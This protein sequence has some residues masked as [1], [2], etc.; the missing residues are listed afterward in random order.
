MIDC[1]Q[2]WATVYSIILSTVRRRRI[3]SKLSVCATIMSPILILSCHTLTL[4]HLS[5]NIQIPQTSQTY[6][7]VVNYQECRNF[8]QALQI[9]IVFYS[10]AICFSFADF[11][12]YHGSIWYTQ[13]E[14]WADLYAN[15]YTICGKYFHLV[16]HQLLTCWRRWKDSVLFLF[17]FMSDAQAGTF[18]K[19]N[20]LTPTTRK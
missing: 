15:I 13:V 11:Q 12:P 10:F 5:G 2:T 1:V 4:S 17:Y 18:C 14:K 20:N 16:T 8:T 9:K 7:G 19:C 3:S 6:P